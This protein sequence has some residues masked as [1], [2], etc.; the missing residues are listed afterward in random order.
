VDINLHGNNLIIGNAVRLTGNRC[1]FSVPTGTKTHHKDLSC[2]H[3][4]EMQ[5]NIFIAEHRRRGEVDAKICI[6]QMGFHD[7]SWIQLITN[8]ER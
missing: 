3:N 4:T 2:I 6:I 1:G 8:I 7:L 5:F